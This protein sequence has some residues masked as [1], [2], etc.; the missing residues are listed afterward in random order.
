MLKSGI[1]GNDDKKHA[2]QSFINFLS[3]SDNVVRNMNYI[4]YT[5]VI[6]GGDNPLVYEYVDYCYGAEEDDTDVIE[7]PVGFFFAGDDED[8][9]Y[10][11]T[12]NPEQADRQL[13]AQYPQM[14]VIKRSAVMQ[15]FDNEAND[16]INQMWI[17]VRCFNLNRIS[18]KQWITF[19]IIA[20]VVII[21]TGI[22]II[23]K[24]K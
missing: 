7:Y 6:S 20:G 11:L 2:A 5:S 21:A 18:A 3:R 8:E 22:I 1:K 19:G 13:S 12:I 16:R 9:N 24:R 15:Y 14:D 17:N 23:K 4:G 10:I